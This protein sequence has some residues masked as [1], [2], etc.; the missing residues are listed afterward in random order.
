MSKSIQKKVLF[1]TAFLASVVTVFTLYKAGLGINF[2]VVS[3]VICLFITGQ[4]VIAKRLSFS[5]ILNVILLFALSVPFGLTTYGGIK[6]VLLMT[7]LY[8]FLNTIYSLTKPNADFEFWR[9]LLAPFELIVTSF[10]IPFIPVSKIKIRKIGSP[11]I[12]LRIILGVIIALPFL[13]IFV[14]LL[15][16]A[17]MVFKDLIGDVFSKHVFS[18]SLQIGFWIGTVSWLLFGVTYYSIFVKK[19]EDKKDDKQVQDE[20]K[21]SSRLLVESVTVLTLV[22]LLFL[23]FNI[24]QIAY[25]FGG[26]SM[27]SGDKFTYSEYARKGFIELVVVSVLALGLIALIFKLKK[28]KSLT[29]KVIIRTLGL[30]GLVEI[31]PMTISA[32][33]R[34]VMYEDAY[35]F[36]R[37]RIYSQLFMVYLIVMFVW[38][39][40]KLSTKLSEEKFLYGTKLLTIASLVIVGFINVDALITKLNVEKYKQEGNEDFLEVQK[41]EGGE[42]YQAYR[43]G[44]Y[45]RGQVDSNYIK[46]LSWDAIPEYIRLFS[47][48]EGDLKEKI[49]FDL[50]REYAELAYRSKTGDFRS[51]NLREYLALKALSENIDSIKS[52]AD[53]FQ[54]E[55]LDKSDPNGYRPSTYDP[56]DDTEYC[57][58][59]SVEMYG[60][61]GYKSSFY[62]PVKFYSFDN[63]NEEV[64]EFTGS[65]NCKEV[66]KGKYFAII[67]R[68]YGSVFYRE[69]EFYVVDIS[70]V[71]QVVKLVRG[72]Y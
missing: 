72:I 20:K 15:A 61:D 9:Y 71:N 8:L 22:E 69:I 33:Y 42:S 17:D 56:Y 37:N 38:F 41:E 52:Y 47:I 18:D 45:S 44:V 6:A 50:N 16:S 54:E 60:K 57:E 27:I 5:L 64:M 30:F 10:V 51:W 68:R 36:T 67:N 2:T 31:L 26:E 25:L 4:A 19:R 7:W 1:F 12:I 43:M 66:K 59:V 23:V 62:Y 14:A 28:T 48:A 34:L 65:E 35:G 53:D 55:L 40:I 46:D 11:A 63:P 13:C 49:A 70:S 24:V 32:F 21:K 39:G 3:L 58:K 29:Q